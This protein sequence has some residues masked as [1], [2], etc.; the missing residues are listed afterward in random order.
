MI[1]VLAKKEN[2]INLSAARCKS[3]FQRYVFLQAAVFSSISYFPKRGHSELW[4]ILYCIRFFVWQFLKSW[5]SQGSR[6]FDFSLLSIWSPRW[7]LIFRESVFTLNMTVASA[8][9]LAGIY[10]RGYT[11]VVILKII[12][13]ST[14]SND[15]TSWRKIH[16]RSVRSDFRADRHQKKMRRKMESL[17]GGTL[18]HRSLLLNNMTAEKRFL[19]STSS[20]AREDL[21]LR[22]ELISIECVAAVLK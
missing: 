2:E 9:T 20:R 19:F 21:W 15:Q 4:F 8:E 7:M 3:N 6:I 5:E 18:E 1:A 22:K 12:I 10:S 14:E 17:L 13:R 11:D 16:F